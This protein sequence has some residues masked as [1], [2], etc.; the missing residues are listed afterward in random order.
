MGVPLI[1]VSKP[2]F[3]RARRPRSLAAPACESASLFAPAAPCRDGL[4][5]NDG[6]C[7][8]TASDIQVCAHVHEG[9]RVPEGV[10]SR[11]RCSV[12]ENCCM[13]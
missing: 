7:M 13:R 9:I 5:C 12:A 10:A 8:F 2:S 3:W 11:R 6:G 4:R 1:S